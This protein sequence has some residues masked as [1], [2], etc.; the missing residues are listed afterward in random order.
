MAKDLFPRVPSG[1]I[2]PCEDAVVS[3]EKLREKLLQ[4]GV[5]ETVVKDCETI[6]LSEV[7]NLQNRLKVLTQKHLIL[8]DTLRQLE[9][10]FGFFPVHTHLNSHLFHI[11]NIFCITN[12]M[13]VLSPC[14]YSGLIDVVL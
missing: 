4:E 8:L 6:M 7:S 3:T 14:P 13:F 10:C 1:D 11:V 12:L 5:G 9:V 2:L